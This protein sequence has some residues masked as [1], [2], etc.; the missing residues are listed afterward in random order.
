MGFFCGLNLASERMPGGFMATNFV[1]TGKTL[2]FTPTSVVASGELVVV[3]DIVVI[4]ITDIA[5]NMQGEGVSEG[6]FILPKLKSDDIKAG[7]K[8]YLKDKKVKL[9]SSDSSAVYAGV[10]WADA[11][12]EAE[13]VPVKINV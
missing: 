13:F 8:V 1:Q 2:S 6:V 11:G 10:A 3:G 7:K 5:V 12:T 9:S 4:A